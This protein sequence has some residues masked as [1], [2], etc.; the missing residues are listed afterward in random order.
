MFE[1]IEQTR[2]EKA[3]YLAAYELFTEKGI[4]NTAIND[5]V[6]KAGVAKGTFYTYFKNK[7]DLLERIILNKS[8]KVLHEAMLATKVEELESFNEGL[9]NFVNYII[10]YFEEDPIMLKLIHKN[11]SW[12]VLRKVR[13]NYKEMND[14][15][16]MFKSEY[17]KEGMTDLEIES[18]LFIIIDLV[19][20]ICY[21]SIILEEP[22]PIDQMRPILFKT[23]E[24]II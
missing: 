20:S 24:N 16:L 4:T 8:M 6:T 3:L 18:L 14:I 21:H 19:G 1:G 5:I 12:G 11:L 13:P 2:R 9:L 23:I 10:Q 7:E 22:A 15:Y 17:E